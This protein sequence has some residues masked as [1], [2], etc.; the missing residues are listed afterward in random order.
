MNNKEVKFLDSAG[1]VRYGRLLEDRGK[2]LL[3]RT[4]PTTWIY[5]PQEIWISKRS[6]IEIK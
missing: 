2:K 3:I 4:S 1:Q 5:S 6:V